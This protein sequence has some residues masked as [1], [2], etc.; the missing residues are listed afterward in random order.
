MAK[1][2][3]GKGKTK[4]KKLHVTKNLKKI[5]SRFSMG[6]L[7][8]HY[9]FIRKLSS[10]SSKSLK[11]VKKLLK[12]ATSGEILVLAEIVLNLLR[13]NIPLNVK[14]KRILCPFRNKLREVASKSTNCEKKR[15]IFSN[16][17]GG[18][19]GIIATILSAAI[20]AI[21][22]LFSSSSS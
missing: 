14:Q 15:V 4:A 19:L 12:K 21:A 22:S 6:R 18:I 10:A 2:N 11:D 7:Q 20:P 5:I 16:Q 1:Y 9:G 17:R 8:K 3:K 13:R